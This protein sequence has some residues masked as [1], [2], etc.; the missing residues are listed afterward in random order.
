MAM[1][2][3]YIAGQTPAGIS[4]TAY[5]ANLASRN[6]SSCVRTNIGQFPSG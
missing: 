3:R 6:I 1:S 5:A 4:Y 2:S